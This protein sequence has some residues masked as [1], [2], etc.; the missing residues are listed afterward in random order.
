MHQSAYDK[1][2]S[3]VSRYLEGHHEKP[4]QILDVGSRAFGV[5]APKQRALFA[6]PSWHY[7]G[8]D[9]EAGDN[10]D[11]VVKEPY[12]WS[13]VKSESVDV[14]VCSQVFEHAQF[15]WA[16]MFEV[17]RVLRPRGLLCMLS[18]SHGY[19]HRYPKDCW[20]F[21]L[22][23]W[24]SLAELAQLRLVEHHV[25]TADCAYGDDS[26]LW[27]DSAVVMQ[28]PAW[29]A[30]DRERFAQRRGHQIRALGCQADLGGVEAGEPSVFA[31][32][33]APLGALASAHELRDNS[34]VVIRLRRSWTYLG[35]SLMAL[36]GKR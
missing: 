23:G 25:H 16:T 32:D 14:L 7:V 24:A 34:R 12:C 19:L 3:F 27:R 18:P 1:M 13:E 4:L 11:V 8:L 2:A 35:V 36:A 21:G 10:V 15:F 22:D 20:R 28:K 9:L 33:L 26:D 17:A 30:A 6:R 29:S 31:P 5:V